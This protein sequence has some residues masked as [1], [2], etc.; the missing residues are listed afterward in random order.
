MDMLREIF[1]EIKGHWIS[2]LIF[3]IVFV[4]IYVFY[5]FF[6][7]V[8]VYVVSSPYVG[9]AMINGFSDAYER[10]SRSIMPVRVVDFTPK[11]TE[12]DIDAFINRIQQDMAYGRRI[13]AIVGT[14]IS[15][16]TKLLLSA[17]TRHGMKIPVIS[18][19]SSS[20]EL[21]NLY[22]RF[23]RIIYNDEPVVSAFARWYT[24]SGPNKPVIVLVDSENI[25]WSGEV[26]RVFKE[27]ASSVVVDEEVV[28]M[29]DPIS[30]KNTVDAIIN[31]YRLNKDD[32]YVF[33]VDYKLADLYKTVLALSGDYR[34]FLMTDSAVKYMFTR[35]FPDGLNLYVYYLPI[36]QVGML[37][38]DYDLSYDA[39][40]SVLSVVTSGAR[41]PDAV[42]KAL[43]N[44][45]FSGRTGTISF[46]ERD[47]VY[48][49][50]FKTITILKA[51]GETWHIV[52]KQNLSE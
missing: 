1:E 2:W 51:E 43:L 23:F 45:K 25:T 42:V 40:A 29:S 19:S 11:N 44:M 8:Y 12:A 22:Y 15:S 13:V 9:P 20:P 39:L 28:N 47:N 35:W 21:K 34:N 10:Y 50:D 3:V 31:E 4:A 26:A 16:E 6:T 33:V 14:D 5:Y 41:S 30:V 52:T 18:Q 17:M 7:P 46:V 27:T 32:V 48:E 36:K 49:R 37:D 38:Y 24:E